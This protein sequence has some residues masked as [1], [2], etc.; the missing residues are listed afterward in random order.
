[1]SGE[2]GR[3]PKKLPPGQAIGQIA[4]QTESPRSAL[5]AALTNAVRDAAGAGDLAA[6]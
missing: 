5:I 2:G 3:G 4:G 1:M 6:V